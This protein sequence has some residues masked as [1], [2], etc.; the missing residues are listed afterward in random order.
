MNEGIS[1]QDYKDASMPEQGPFE[2]TP[3]KRDR[4]QALGSEVN[5]EGNYQ[6]AR[7]YL[8]P[9]DL[10]RRQQFTN[11]AEAVIDLANLPDTEFVSAIEAVA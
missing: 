10:Q 3:I 7:L 4:R 1:A 5:S 6:E 8:S 11:S 2:P 9:G